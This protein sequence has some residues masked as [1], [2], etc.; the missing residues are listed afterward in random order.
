V[1][2]TPHPRRVRRQGRL[3]PHRSRGW[4]PLHCWSS[5]VRLRGRDSAGLAR[6]P[7]EGGSWPGRRATFRS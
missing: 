1:A 3:G 6:Q 5:G 2:L 4:R 7:V